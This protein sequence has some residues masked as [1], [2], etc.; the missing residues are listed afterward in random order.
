MIDFYQFIYYGIFWSYIWH[1]ILALLKYI[2]IFIYNEHQENISCK[3]VSIY[4]YIQQIGHYSLHIKLYLTSN[5]RLSGHL[6]GW[7]LQ[8]SQEN[9]PGIYVRILVY[10][11]QLSSILL[12]RNDFQHS[13]LD[14]I[15]HWIMNIYTIKININCQQ[16]CWNLCSHCLFKHEVIFWSY[17]WYSML[18][19]IKYII[20]F[21]LQWTSRKYFRQLC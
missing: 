18:D 8:L 6:Y 16:L 5:V 19:L 21:Y 14:Y 12:Q 11:L 3:Y 17:I 4:D 15:Y 9:I 10:I 20:I 13:M 7:Y 2:I 1:S